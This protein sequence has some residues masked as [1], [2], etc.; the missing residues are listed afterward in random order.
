MIDFHFKN[1]Q[2]TKDFAATFVL[3]SSK[4]THVYLG[5]ENKKQSCSMRTSNL[6]GIVA[7]MITY[8]G[9]SIFPISVWLRNQQLSFRS[10]VYS[11]REKCA[12]E[13]K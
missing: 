13:T 10:L 2:I 3:G 7:H 9:P 11:H 8:I 4:W 5:F 6:C 1:I 12:S